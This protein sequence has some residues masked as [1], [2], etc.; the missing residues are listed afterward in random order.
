MTT[1]EDRVIVSAVYFLLLASAADLVVTRYLLASFPRHEANP[2]MAPLIASWASVLVKVGL[3]S[4]IGWRFLHG[5]HTRFI[6][7]QLCIGMGIYT[8][9]LI[10][11]LSLAI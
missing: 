10:H 9:V 11:N 5:P 1:T 6:A 3:P 8:A 4:L 2:L 7:C